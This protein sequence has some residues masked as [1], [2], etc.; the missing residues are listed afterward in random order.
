M[1]AMVSAAGATEAA[2]AVAALPTEPAAILAD[3]NI[4]YSSTFWLKEIDV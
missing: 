1:P 3:S 4:I 2:I